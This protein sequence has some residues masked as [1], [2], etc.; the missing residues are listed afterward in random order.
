MG[1][2]WRLEIHEALPSTSDHLAAAAAAG[3]AEGLAVL[4][5]RQTAG[6]GRAGRTWATPPGNL[7]LSVLLRPGGQAGEAPQW[8]LLAGV[9][10]AEAA[11][12]IDP[13]P[14]LLR[15][16]WPNDLLRQG[17]KV[18]GILVESA[19]TPE[20][21]VGWIGI[22]IGANLAEAPPVPDRPIARLGAVEPA[23]A[24]AQRVLARLDHWRAVR[25]AA[26]FGPVRQA[27]LAR[28]PALGQ[29]VSVRGA[30]IPGGTFAG[31]AS[32]GALLLDHAGARHVLRT[33]ELRE[34]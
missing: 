7:A 16:K 30:A 12:E 1:G 2:F 29:P 9:A 3:A 21:G 34:A 13:E 23:E 18:G 14:A 19:L 26:G 8:A 22:G 6:R 20:G 32:D 4:A 15:L 28:G 11:A 27:W 24:F 31:L 17:A 5:L 10:L 33:G 25:A